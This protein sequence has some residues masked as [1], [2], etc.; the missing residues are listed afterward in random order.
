MLK[1]NFDDPD[2]KN[3]DSEDSIMKML[4]FLVDFIFWR[5]FFAAKV[6]QIVGISMGTKCG[7]L[8]ADIFLYSYEAGF[9]QSLLSTKRKQ[10]AS[11]FN[12]TYRYID[13]VLTVK[14]ESL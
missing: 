2:S 10:L 14:P 4:E 6:Q 12:F 1:N 11:R 5:F 8:L 7:P 13:N 3:N 9:I